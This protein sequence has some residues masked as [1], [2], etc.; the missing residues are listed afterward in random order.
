MPYVTGPHSSL[1]MRRPT[2]DYP[3]ALTAHE[4]LCAKNRPLL[5]LLK[6]WARRKHQLHRAWLAVPASERHMYSRIVQGLAREHSG[7]AAQLVV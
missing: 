2:S 4:E 1:I 6:D 7:L 5:V 3:P